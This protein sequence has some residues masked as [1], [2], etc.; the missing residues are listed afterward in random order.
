MKLTSKLP[1]FIK[2][3]LPAL[4][5]AVTGLIILLM[6]QG[7]SLMGWFEDRPDP[8]QRDNYQSYFA[9]V[10]PETQVIMF[11]TQWCQYC[12]KARDY[13]TKN[14]IPFIDND[15][16]S[17]EASMAIF[18][19]LRGQSYPLILSRDVKIIGFD[20]RIYDQLLKTNES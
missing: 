4:A 10:T 11:G 5:G 19:Q 7:Q 2:D 17:S 6:V 14:N 18:N 9:E 13:F 15:V 20:K 16:E 8:I 3:M 12:A 1:K